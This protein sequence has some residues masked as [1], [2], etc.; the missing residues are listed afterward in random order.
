MSV[1]PVC[2]KSARDNLLKLSPLEGEPESGEIITSIEPSQT[3]ETLVAKVINKKTQE[4]IPNV[5][6]KLEL[7]VKKDS[8][9]HIHAVHNPIVTS[10]TKGKL[11]SLNSQS[12]SDMFG[13]LEGNTGDQGLQ[14]TYEAPKLAGDIVITGSCTSQ[15]CKRDGADTIWVGI[16]GLWKLQSSTIYK[17]LP[18]AFRHSGCHYFTRAA[19][20]NFN[21]VARVYRSANFGVEPVHV[22]DAS[23]ERGGLF[24]IG[25][26]WT[27]PHT[28]HRQGRSID[29]YFTKPD[30]MNSPPGTASRI[31][32]FY[33]IAKNRGTKLQEKFIEDPELRKTYELLYFHI[34]IRR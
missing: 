20:G 25:G 16:K 23:L 19:L 21:I 28:K 12:T 15:Y 17:T 30:P 8:G 2:D 14:F 34:E 9:G 29:V 18:C 6:I 24:D 3:T 26:N 11:Q 22:G 4:I 13:T 7:D 5:D 1:D 27:S 33:V 10:N 32:S 31:P